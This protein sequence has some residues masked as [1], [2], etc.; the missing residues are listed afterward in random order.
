MDS[1]N[2][3]LDLFDEDIFSQYDSN[4]VG[5][6]NTSD[7]DTNII[8]GK[9]Y[10]TELGKI[11]IDESTLL[12]QKTIT[13]VAKRSKKFTPPVKNS[14]I[15]TKIPIQHNLVEKQIFTHTNLLQ[16][17]MEIDD[18]NI[19]RSSITDII[20]KRFEKRTHNNSNTTFSLDGLLLGSLNLLNDVETENVSQALF[21][22]DYS[23]EQPKM[24]QE[25][26]KMSQESKNTILSFNSDNYK[27]YT[28]LDLK[29]ENIQSQVEDGS[30]KCQ[31][32]IEGSLYS[33]DC[34]DIDKNNNIEFNQSVDYKIPTG[35]VFLNLFKGGK[36]MKKFDKI[37]AMSTELGDKGLN[38]KYS[39]YIKQI[40]NFEKTS[41]TSDVVSKIL[42]MYPNDNKIRL[43]MK[44]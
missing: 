29:S 41:D 11:P 23:Q 44:N 3:E 14:T 42:K 9:S 27:I 19:E 32:Q 25:Q 38:V 6:L 10:K 43:K 28:N 36:C 15:N 34:I 18:L 5:I 7:N 26:A 40:G 17:P 39:D 30:F 35:D 20:E 13:S 16:S 37:V 12:S 24:S 8:E 21:T 33:T 31:N 22:E 4:L 2:T 1:L